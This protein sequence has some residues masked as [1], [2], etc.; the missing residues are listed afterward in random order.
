MI[1][2]LEE[3]YNAAGGGASLPCS[4]PRRDE[5]QRQMVARQSSWDPARH[6]AREKRATTA[7]MR[8]AGRRAENAPGRSARRLAAGAD[9]L[10]HSSNA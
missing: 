1:Q 6:C 7:A 8:H 3:L 10:T 5:W 4:R 9:K 2:P